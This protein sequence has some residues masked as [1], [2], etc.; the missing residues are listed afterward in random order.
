MQKKQQ[1]V[2]TLIKHNIQVEKQKLLFTLENRIKNNKNT[3]KYNQLTVV[4]S[5]ICKRIKI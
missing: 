1:R 5:T 4:E 3:L 2:I